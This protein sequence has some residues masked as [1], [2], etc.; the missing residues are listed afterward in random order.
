MHGP[1]ISQDALS[2]AGFRG[3]PRTDGRCLAIWTREPSPS[4]S[5][6]GVLVNGPFSLRE[7]A[8]MG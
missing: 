4:P 8:G 6:R 7:Q 5:G 1:G 3:Q 2:D